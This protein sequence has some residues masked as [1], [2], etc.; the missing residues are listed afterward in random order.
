MKYLGHIIFLERVAIDL[1]KAEIVRNL[2]TPQS[3]KELRGFVGLIGWYR[4]FIR[5]FGVII[6]LLIK[7]LKKNIFN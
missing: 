7:K 2:P 6:I 1:N 3:V 4:K 5:N